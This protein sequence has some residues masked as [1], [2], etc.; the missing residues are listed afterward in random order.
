MIPVRSIALSFSR[1]NPRDAPF[2]GPRWWVAAGWLAAALLAQTTIL[3]YVT[4]RGVEP[5]LVLVVVIWYAT[6]VEIRRATAFGV[7]AGVCEDILAST[8]GGAWTIAT[9]LVA[10]FVGTLSSGFFADSIPLVT[11]M[12][13][14]ATLVRAL[15]FWMVMGFEGYPSGLGGIHFHAA[16]VQAV[17]NMALMVIAMVIARR[18]DRRFG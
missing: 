16:L 3:H 8:T 13:G 6:R 11:A 5:S 10:L 2:V 7:A 18:F 12:T 14:L 15:L 9:T 17:L 1:N 4:V